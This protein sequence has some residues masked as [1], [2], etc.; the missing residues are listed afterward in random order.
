MLKSMT[1]VPEVPEALREELAKTAA[2][3]TLRTVVARIG[4]RGAI[5]SVVPISLFLVL[6][7][8]AGIVWA[9]GAAT[10]WA[11]AVAIYRLIRE[12]RTSIF[13][14]IGLA[15]VLAR[16][17]A[18]MLTHSKLVFFGPGVAQ[19]AVIGLVFLVSTIVRRPAVGYIA[20]IVYPF[21][22][23]VRQHPAYRRAMTHLTL[24]WAAY[25]LAHVAM[26]VYLLKTVSA[27]L[28]VVIRSVVSW[29]ILLG[30]FVFSLRYPRRV[31][32]RVPE[33]LPYVEAAEGRVPAAA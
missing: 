13:L 9:V 12:G 19:T 15:Y 22:D 2:A 20:P 26:D 10:V 31:F 33:L 8:T 30:L 25:L 23:F 14:W 4:W 16:G 24:V 18:A 29:P 11:V 21:Q 28:Y 27:S 3:P 6:N 17:A 32:R 5:D 1:S 7:V